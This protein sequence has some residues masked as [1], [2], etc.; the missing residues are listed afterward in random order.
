[1]AIGYVTIDY[2]TMVVTTTPDGQ[3]ELQRSGPL[4]AG[5]WAHGR[6]RTV[7]TVRPRLRSATQTIAARSSAAA[8]PTSGAL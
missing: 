4:A 3:G 8:A 2:V 1:M 6:G 5:W 7:V